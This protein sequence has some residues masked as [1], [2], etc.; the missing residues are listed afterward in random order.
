MPLLPVI[1]SLIAQRIGELPLEWDATVV[2]LT[3]VSFVVVA[4]AIALVQQVQFVTTMHG[5]RMLHGIRDFET[6]VAQHPGVVEMGDGLNDPMT[7]ERPMLVF[8]NK[9]HLL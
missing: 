2:R 5:R 9:A 3:L 6:F 4:A 7:F 1:A 8:R